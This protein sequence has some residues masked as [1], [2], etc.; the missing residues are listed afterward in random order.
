[1]IGDLILA[2][3]LQGF[4]NDRGFNEAKKLLGRFQ[5]VEVAGFDVAVAAARNYRK[6]RSLGV[7]VRGTVDV[8]I[9]T[10]CIESRLRLL[11]NDRDFE[12]FEKDL[13]LR[14]VSCEA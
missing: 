5:Q 10:R 12:P 14:V 13:A 9:A 7:T 3:V 1:M 8:L 11:H 2:D 4:N 6:L